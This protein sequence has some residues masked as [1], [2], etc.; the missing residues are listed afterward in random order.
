MFGVKKLLYLGS[1]CIYPRE[2]AQ[3]MTEAALPQ[4]ARITN[5]P[6]IANRRHQACQAYA[7]NGCNFIS[8]MP[9]NLRAERQFRSDEPHVPPALI[10]KFHDARMQGLQEVTVWDSHPGASS[11]MSMIWLTPAF[12]MERYEGDSHINVGT[13]KTDD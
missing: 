7:A 13:E 9:T 11:F 12:L 1:S 10:R 4:A 6:M 5:S 2:S 3:P 8:A